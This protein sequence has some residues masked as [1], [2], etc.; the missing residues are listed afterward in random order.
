MYE[1]TIGWCT[2]AALMLI[3]H[4]FARHLDFR[5]RYILGILAILAGLAVWAALTGLWGAWIATAVISTGGGVV[6]IAYAL[7]W[8]WDKELRAAREAG[9]IQGRVEE[10]NRGTTGVART[11]DH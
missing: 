3:E 1:L 4:L 9:R 7:R 10:A 6:I 5:V 11:R 8:L 2:A